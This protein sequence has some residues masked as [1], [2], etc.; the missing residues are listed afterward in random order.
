MFCKIPR[1]QQ[2]SSYWRLKALIRQP[3]LLSGEDSTFS[4]SFFNVRFHCGRSKF[5]L[6]TMPTNRQTHLYRM[7]VKTTK[8]KDFFFGVGRTKVAG[9]RG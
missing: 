7:N 8:T 2:K 3:D 5:E 6:L 9:V 4:R 1:R